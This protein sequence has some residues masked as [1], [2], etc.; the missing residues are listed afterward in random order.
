MKG[1]PGVGDIW[2]QLTVIQAHAVGTIYSQVPFTSL[3]SLTYHILRRGVH[4]LLGSY[5]TTSMKLIYLRTVKGITNIA[6]SIS[7][8][9]P[10]GSHRK[11][12]FS[13]SF[14]FSFF[15]SPLLRK[16]HYNNDL[17]KIHFF[18]YNRPAVL[19]AVC[20]CNVLTYNSFLSQ[21]NSNR[22]FVEGSKRCVCE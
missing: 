13:K 22:R 15:F 19:S 7:H 16:Q 8:P 20:R 2:D 11:R 4:G 5:I 18:C 14:R 6:Q 10:R 12:L 3:L 17:H 21:L 1:K 9:K